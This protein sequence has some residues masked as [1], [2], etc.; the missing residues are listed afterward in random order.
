MIHQYQRFTNDKRVVVVTAVLILIAVIFWTGSRYPALQEK[1]IMGGD[2]TLSG[3]GF[4]PLVTVSGEDSLVWQILGNSVNWIYTNLQGMTFG[5]LFAAILLTLIS[6]LNGREK[7][8]VFA[9]TVMG[10]IIGVPLGVCVNCATPIAKGLHSGGARVETSLATM[11][12]SPTLN[13]IVLAMLFSLFPTYVGIIKVGLT[14]CFLLIGI[15]LLAKLWPENAPQNLPMP[16]NIASTFQPEHSSRG[17][18]FSAVDEPGQS[19]FAAVKWSGRHFIKN[20]WF[21]VKTTVPLMLLAGFL[22][23]LFVTI[24]PFDSLAEILP[25]KGRLVM[26]VGMGVVAL[27]G[28]FL[29]VPM[30]FDVIVVAV[31]S[32]A[33]M[34]MKY[35]LT[36]LFTLGMFSVYPFFVIWQSI[37]KKVALSIVIGLAVL[38][39]GAGFLGHNVEKVAVEQRQQLFFDTFSGSDSSLTVPV[40]QRPVT[41]AEDAL[42]STLRLHAIQPQSVETAVS[43]LTIQKIPWQTS[44]FLNASAP[45]FTQLSANELGF[46]DPVTTFSLLKFQESFTHVPG[47]ASGDVHQDGWID[48]VLPHDTG[49]GLYANQQGRR[50][51][52]QAIDIPQMDSYTIFN[53]A[54]VDLDNDGWLD[55]YFSTYRQ[56]NFV[57]YN[58]DGRFLANNMQQLPNSPSVVVTMAPAFG[59]ID[60]DGDLD[61][62]LGNWSA[63]MLT[64]RSS[65]LAR[66]VILRNDGDRFTVQHL[67][68]RDGETLTTLLSDWNND[69]LL[70]LV[71]GNDFTLPDYYYIG[72]GNGGF[73][74]V[75]SGDEIIPYTT[76]TT[77]SVTTADINNDLVAELFSAQIT[78][79]GLP[80][81]SS[82]EKVCEELKESEAHDDCLSLFTT[83]ETIGMSY[84]KRDVQG[85]LNLEASQDREE[86]IGMHIV[87]TAW[88]EENP[89]LC[90]LLPQ[91]WEKAAFMCDLVAKQ[92]PR[93]PSADDLPQITEQ[94]ILL[95]LEDGQ[96]VDSVAEFGLDWGGWSWNAKFADL[97][98]DEWQDL[99][100]VN[101]IFMTRKQ[102]LSNAFYHNQQG[103][104]FIDETESTGLRTLLDFQAYTYID[105]DNDGDLDIFAVPAVGQLRVYVNHSTANNSIAF[106]LRDGIGNHFGIASKVII[107]YGAEGERVQMREI[108]ASGGYIS[109]D[110]P[111]AYFGLGEYDAIKQVE[112][113]WSTGEQSVIEGPFAAGARYIIARD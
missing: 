19:W 96:F 110:A 60:Q 53:T 68:G 83:Q 43:R 67:A 35:S 90:G 95:V 11:F 65:E 66:N 8:G 74:L 81:I 55:I 28:L 14:L 16:A 48:I 77:M 76:K 59:D 23:A 39:V 105:F 102:T 34:P 103:Q 5:I 29:P 58:E 18:I 64:D 17:N 104:H 94:N 38:G 47:I 27:V 56:G 111:I 44:D 72:D 106:E 97:D 112:V 41:Q 50:F 75:T 78:S 69:G 46:S 87:W 54:L 10:V 73:Q 57:I 40:W 24:L 4:R 63:G 33:G 71:V 15:P 88:W 2:S 98:N 86:C 84:E 42:L 25:D 101:G 113:I 89:A 52:L 7:R 92:A 22:G 32:A 108:Q 13:V 3:L 79:N 100:I 99:F 1:A 107:H 6:L 26:A 85:C 49:L 82:P 91:G 93:N 62:V 30:A 12:S 31:L 109:F 9:N 45:M 37:S 80:N 21:I 51:V 70:D 20:L 61:I 36:L